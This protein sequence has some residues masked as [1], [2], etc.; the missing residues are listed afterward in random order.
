MSNIVDVGTQ[1]RGDLFTPGEM[2]TRF[3]TGK[4]CT[5]DVGTQTS[6]D[7]LSPAERDE[8]HKDECK[9]WRVR[10]KKKNSNLLPSERI[11]SKVTVNFFGFF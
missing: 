10:E 4:L 8:L 11:R 9:W 2:S 1:T 5:V 6:K 3:R 7:L